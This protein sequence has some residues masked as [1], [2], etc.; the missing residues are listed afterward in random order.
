[1]TNG[2]TPC[3]EAETISLMSGSSGPADQE[4]Y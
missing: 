4:P 2:S 3:S 1:M